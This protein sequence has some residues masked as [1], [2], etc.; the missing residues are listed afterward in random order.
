[1]ND[2]N[3]RYPIFTGSD[4][5]GKE[6]EF[7]LLTVYFAFYLKNNDGTWFSWRNDTD[8]IDYDQHFVMFQESRDVQW[9]GTEDLVFYNASGKPT[10][11]YDY[12]DMIVR[13]N[14]AGTPVPEPTT[15]LLLGLGLLGLVPMRKKL[16][17]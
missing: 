14:F 4:L 17:K 1:M 2:R 8:P 3:K 9:F 16:L 10:S 12:N 11:D 5:A 6:V 13:I 15:L 7:P